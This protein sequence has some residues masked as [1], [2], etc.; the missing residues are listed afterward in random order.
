MSRREQP[1]ISPIEQQPS[2]TP[3]AIA[4]DPADLRSA[5]AFS[6]N[7]EL[8]DNPLF[9]PH[10]GTAAW[11]ALTH[12]QVIPAILASL[13]A[14]RALNP[15]TGCIEENPQ[16]LPPVNVVTSVLLEKDRAEKDKTIALLCALNYP[17]TAEI[18]RSLGSAIL[19]ATKDGLVPID[20]AKKVAEQLAIK[21]PAPHAAHQST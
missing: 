21:L 2:E 17:V 12:Q 8:I 16:L 10:S 9:S 7:T 11:S 19:E 18:R 6:M 20:L 14:F 1:I 15:L 3:V 13:I 5:L 4:I